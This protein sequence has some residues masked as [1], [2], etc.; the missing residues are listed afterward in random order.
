MPDWSAYLQNAQFGIGLAQALSNG[1]G[2]PGMHLLEQVN[3]RTGRDAY[4]A[5]GSGA[6]E[7]LPVNDTAHFSYRR[8]PIRQGS[9]NQRRCYEW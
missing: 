7:G 6:L 9:V 2:Q 1:E 5:A 8:V 3:G 4:P